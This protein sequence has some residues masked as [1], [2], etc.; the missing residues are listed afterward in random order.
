MKKYFFLLWLLATKI[1]SVAEANDQQIQQSLNIINIK[2]LDVQPSPVANLKTVFTK[3]GILYITNDGQYILHGPM[4]NIINV[5]PI[6]ITNKMLVV[7][8]LQKLVSEM[9]IYQ[10]YKEKYIITVFTDI[11]C[12]YCHKLHS[13][14]KE[15][16]N[17][18]ITVRYLA[19]PR[20]GLKSKVAKDMQ[21]IWCTM[22]RYH[23]FNAAIH[24]KIIQQP[25]ICNIDIK[26][27]YELGI[28][29]GIQGT[30]AIIFND[31]TVINGYYE[32]KEILTLLNTKIIQ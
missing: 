17:L 27:H 3:N 6:N 12:K 4:Y 21:L 15:Y 16:N 2:P 8:R 32:P 13:Q 10:A 1:M 19:F 30:P 14:I 31:G 5:N 23:I 20:N 7:S 11:T 18:G 25:L 9:I 29:F 22:N 28:Q 26:K 24:N